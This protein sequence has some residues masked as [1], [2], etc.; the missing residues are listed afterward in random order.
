[1][2]NGYDCIKC[3]KNVFINIRLKRKLIHGI[4]QT[5]IKLCWVKIHNH[6]LSPGNLISGRLMLRSILIKASCNNKLNDNLDLSHKYMNVGKFIYEAGRFFIA[7]LLWLCTFNPMKSRK[8]KKHNQVLARIVP[9]DARMLNTRPSM[10]IVLA[11]CLLCL[12]VYH[13]RWLLLKW[14][15]SRSNIWFETKNSYLTNLFKGDHTVL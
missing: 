5:G 10:P 6:A 1:M 8:I 15:H 11:H 7:H 13:E 12:I 3:M 2:S 14:I 9:T 4:Q